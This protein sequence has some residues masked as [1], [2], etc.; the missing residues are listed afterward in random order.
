MRKGA[1]VATLLATASP[2]SAAD[3]L[4]RD[5]VYVQPETGY[6]L[7]FLPVDP[8]RHPMNASNAFAMVLPGSDEKLLGEV[9]WGNGESRPLGVLRYGCPEPLSDE[10][11]EACTHWQ[12]VVY[13]FGGGELTLLPAE[14]QPAPEQILLP[15]L[16]QVLRY[17]QVFFDLRLG[18]VPWDVFRFERCGD[19]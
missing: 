15:N 13:G 7:Q 2:C 19:P 8:E 16:G 5:A 6:A 12:G 4:L 14:D 17:S 10:A 3:C 9:T 18:E 11:A 1:M